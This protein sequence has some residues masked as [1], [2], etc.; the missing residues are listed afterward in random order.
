[1]VSEKGITPRPN[2]KVSVHVGDI[3]SFPQKSFAVVYLDA[4]NNRIILFQ[5][6]TSHFNGIVLDTA[7]LFEDIRLGTASVIPGT[8][9]SVVPD[10]NDP[11]YRKRLEV[12]NDIIK[13]FGPDFLDL[14][15]KKSKPD[16]KKI[17]H[18]HKV[19]VPFVWKIIRLFLQSGCDRTAL[20]PNKN[21]E[22]NL[23]PEKAYARR[24]AKAKEEELRSNVI[25]HNNP[26]IIKIFKE[27]RKRI[28]S[29]HFFGPSA[30]YEDM[31]SKYFMQVKYTSVNGKI[32]SLE[33]DLMPAA[34]MP[35]FRQFYYWFNQNSTKKEREIAKIGVLEYKNNRRLLYGDTFSNTYGPGYFFESDH[36]EVPVYLISKFSNDT[37]SKATLSV[38]M[39][40]YCA[41]PVGINL[42]F[43]NNS[44][45][46]FTSVELSLGKSK[47]ELCE[48]YGVTLK[49]E[50]DWPSRYIPQNM[51]IDSGPD[52]TSANTERFCQENGIH[53][54]PVSPGVGSY[55]PNVERFFHTLGTYLASH[56]EGK[57]YISGFPNSHPEQHACLTIDD[58][59][60]IILD[61]TIAYI[62]MPRLRFKPT[63]DMIEKNI[64]LSPLGIYKYGVEKYGATT[65]IINYKEF[66]WSL[67]MDDIPA[68]ISSKHGLRFH[69]LDYV[70]PE[71]H[72]LCALM[73]EAGEKGKPFAVRY[74]PRDISVVYYLKDGEPKPI[75]LKSSYASFKGMTLYEYDKYQEK[76]RRKKRL[77]K[78][79]HLKLKAIT[80]LHAKETIKAASAAQSFKP[81]TKNMRE[82]M[83]FEK[84]Y[85]A[86]DNSIVSEFD[87]SDVPS[88]ENAG[89]EPLNAQTNTLTNNAMDLD[90]A[91]MMI[92]MRQRMDSAK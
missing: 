10:E 51:R 89:Q 85:V 42:S 36:W 1:M 11:V 44:N 27:Y 50:D 40:D 35:T 64:D 14:L 77:D 57:G 84:E 70:D 68:T 75:P 34:D 88:D 54:E 63:K 2:F 86:N 46:A 62:K 71:N 21:K 23:D 74:D 87:K 80:R 59:F 28:L 76:A 3:V 60:R 61:F 33:Y 45:R 53:P 20:F 9:S 22:R 65:P 49:N 92:S 15:G 58:L 7:R 79:Q 56:L 78:R 66:L 41:L 73:E 16:L 82:V 4:S 24:G 8:H 69:G 90:P 29:K 39:D 19:S 52:F 32:E 31:V 17:A 12:L 91:E 6:D 47:K 72:E 25:V 5:R 30:A 13:A 83:L 38:I 81:G 55:K 18:R 43:D 48:K 67:L 37:V 26:D